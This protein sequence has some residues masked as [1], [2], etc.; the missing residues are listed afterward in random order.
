MGKKIRS[1]CQEG[2]AA[3]WLLIVMLSLQGIILVKHVL[4]YWKDG[5][6]WVTQRTVSESEERIVGSEE[7][8][9]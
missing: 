5:V 1:L 6:S 8:E 3:R 9:S 7:E 2:N 4:D